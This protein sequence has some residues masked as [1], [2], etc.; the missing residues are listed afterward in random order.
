VAR[1]SRD[2]GARLGDAS[3]A[4]Q[5]LTYHSA[6]D[7]YHLRVESDASWADTCRRLGVT[8]ADGTTRFAD[9]RFD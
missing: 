7:R 4:S 9:A 5:T 8:L 1:A 3:A 2:G 6:Q